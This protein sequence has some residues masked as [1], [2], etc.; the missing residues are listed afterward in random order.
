MLTGNNCLLGYLFNSLLIEK[1]PPKKQCKNVFR[2]CR[3]PYIYIKSVKILL[4]KEGT[5]M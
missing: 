2:V 4:S 1:S 3:H 5:F